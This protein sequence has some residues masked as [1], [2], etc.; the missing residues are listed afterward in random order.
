MALYK[1]MGGK[2]CTMNHR[3]VAATCIASLFMS[4]CSTVQGQNQGP[5]ETGGMIV[6]GLAGG[7]LGYQF[8]SGAG[9]IVGAGLGALAG[10]LAC[11]YIGKSM[12]N[13]ARQQQRAYRGY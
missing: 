4:A 13:N 7:L 8:G 1:L 5:N 11:D 2:G 10:G 6:G 12:D 9:S 3:F